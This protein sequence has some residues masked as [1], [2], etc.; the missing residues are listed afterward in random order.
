MQ[1]SG[2]EIAGGS[3]RST[4]SPTTLLGSSTPTTSRGTVT[5]TPSGHGRGAEVPR[6]V[7]RRYVPPVAP[8]RPRGR[9]RSASL[10]AALVPDRERP[11]DQPASRRGLSRRL[12]IGFGRLGPT[13]IKLG[14]ILSSGDGIFPEEVVSQFKQ[15]RDRVPAESFETVR[16]NR[17]SPSSPDASRTRSPSSDPTPIAA[18]SIAQVHRAVLHSGEHVVVK[19][20]RPRV[21]RA[22]AP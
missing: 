16:S 1:T 5:S 4:P 21:V 15:L 9:R 2:S 10:L 8:D 6:L 17:S 13:Y 7:R 18:A 14:Q 20:Q 11:Q 12:R 3:R 19:V 22:R